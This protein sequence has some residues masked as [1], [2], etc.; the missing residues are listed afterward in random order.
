MI[1]HIE[2]DFDI[3]DSVFMKDRSEK[4]VGHVI[5]IIVDVQG[6]M[7]SVSWVDSGDTTRHYGFELTRKYEKR[8]KDEEESD[9]DLDVE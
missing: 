2:V 3:M 1:K 4:E 8:W 9:A 7:Y 5:N 6:V